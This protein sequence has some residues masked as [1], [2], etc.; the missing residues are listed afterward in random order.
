MNRQLPK[1]RRRHRRRDFSIKFTGTKIS[2]TGVIDTAPEI[3]HARI[4][5]ISEGGLGL[6]VDHRLNRFDLIRGE[7]IFPRAS[8]GVP[9]LLQVRW[10]RRQASSRFPYHVGLQFLL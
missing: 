5:N 3:F 10:V 7:V 6:T 2:P 4:H 8:I 9:S 1:E